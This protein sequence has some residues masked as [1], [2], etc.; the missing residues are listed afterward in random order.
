MEHSNRA[1]VTVRLPSV[2]QT[3]RGGREWETETEKYQ[4]QPT[5]LLK[6]REAVTK[7]KKERKR[8]KKLVLLYPAHS[9]YWLFPHCSPPSIPPPPLS[10]PSLLHHRTSG[11][12]YAPSCHWIILALLYCSG[13]PS[14]AKFKTSP[15]LQKHSSGRSLSSYKQHRLKFRKLFC[16]SLYILKHIYPNESGF[17]Y[18]C[19]AKHLH[20]KWDFIASRF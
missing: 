8:K 17:N 13:L 18:P 4:A 9:T 16:S 14:T 19:F 7:K 12:S 3:K 6:R 11:C 20:R 1:V 2:T 15:V 5:V 10:P